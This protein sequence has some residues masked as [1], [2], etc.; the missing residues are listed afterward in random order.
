MRKEKE[1]FINNLGKT[2]NINSYYVVS[3]KELKTSRKKTKYID[4]NLRDKTGT[5]LGRIFN[6]DSR[7]MGGL[8]DSIETGEIYQINGKMNEYP[9]GSGNLNII[10]DSLYKINKN[11]CDLND[12]IKTPKRS[13]NELIKVIDKKIN[14]IQDK[15][16]KK[17]LESIFNDNNFRNKFIYAPSAKLHHHN[18]ISGLLEHTVEVLE[19]CEVVSSQFDKINGDM[20]TAGAILHD[21]GKIRSYDYDILKIEISEDEKL[22]GHIYSSAKMINRKAEK[23]NT[24]KEVLDPLIHII[25]SHHG[26]MRNGWGSPIDPKTPEALSLHYA[27]NLNAKVQDLIQR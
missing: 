13:K 15:D 21:I 5:I 18:Y 25:L 4:V 1:S 27:D 2:G 3:D 11:Y 20:L 8:F 23:L 16:L 19:I 14:T 12:F 17:L 9:P 26:E 6:N 7:D 10:I 22:F 24:P